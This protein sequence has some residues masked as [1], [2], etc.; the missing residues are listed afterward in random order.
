ME[1]KTCVSGCSAGLYA[2]NL[3]KTCKISC[4]SDPFTFA[5]KFTNKCVFQCSPSYYGY[6]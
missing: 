5:D 1:N 3:T 6:F 4:P 2:D